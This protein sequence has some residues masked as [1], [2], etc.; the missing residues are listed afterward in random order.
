MIA[1][2]DV[3]GGGA[4]YDIYHKFNLS[5]A[6]ITDTGTIPYCLESE[7]VIMVC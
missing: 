5:F 7:S 6:D 2:R 4:S 3:K 1:E